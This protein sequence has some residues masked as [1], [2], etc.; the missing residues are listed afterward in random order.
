VTFTVPDGQVEVKTL[1]QGV[2]ELCNLADNRERS[3]A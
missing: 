3:A 1:T 2:S